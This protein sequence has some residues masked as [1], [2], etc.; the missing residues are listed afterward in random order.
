MSHEAFVSEHSGL[1]QHAFKHVVLDASHHQ[2]MPRTLE[3]A[4]TLWGRP[5]ILLLVGKQVCSGNAPQS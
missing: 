4:Q 2:L 3:V 1:T 5:S